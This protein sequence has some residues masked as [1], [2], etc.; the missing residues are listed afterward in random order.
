MA[1]LRG[2]FRPASGS[3]G[4][5]A[6]GAPPSP[7][8]GEMGAAAGRA[9]EGAAEEPPP[10]R[11]AARHPARG[12]RRPRRWPR[13]DWGAGVGV[14]LVV[15]SARGV[16]G[17]SSCVVGEVCPIP[18][19]WAEDQTLAGCSDIGSQPVCLAAGLGS[20]GILSLAAEATPLTS[21]L[22]GYE[23]GAALSAGSCA[24]PCA[25]IEELVFAAGGVG[26]QQLS[27]APA[28]RTCS[29]SCS[30][31]D[32]GC[33]CTTGVVLAPGGVAWSWTFEPSDTGT[34]ALLGDAFTF[35]VCTE[36]PCA[37]PSPPPPALPF[38]PPPSPTPVKFDLLGA[39]LLMNAVSRRVHWVLATPPSPPTSGE[40]RK[41]RRRESENKK[42]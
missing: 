40:V 5:A 39:C 6:G 30:L 33:S 37:P 14:V 21:P 38:G 2:S 27:L 24:E 13:S 16:L 1:G 12:H 4:R 31:G 36:I 19:G 7:R 34:H 10:P 8:P 20:D 41:V 3:R 23:G 35:N 11:G 9:R 26:Q 42:S 22:P 17:G 29:G 25:A 32:E 18:S 15:G 28:L